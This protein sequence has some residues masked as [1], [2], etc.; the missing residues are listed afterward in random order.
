[1]S[2]LGK[3]RK[4]SDSWPA[5]RQVTYSAAA[6]VFG[7]LTLLGIFT[8]ADVAKYLGHTATVLTGIG[9]LVYVLASLYTPNPGTTKAQASATAGAVAEHKDHVHWAPVDPPTTEIP[10]LSADPFIIRDQG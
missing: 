4:V 8:D 7:A 6:T 3:L 5:I 10:R 2:T 9:T 1:M